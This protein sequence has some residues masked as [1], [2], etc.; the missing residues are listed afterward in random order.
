ME[1]ELSNNVLPK[2]VPYKKKPY[3]G[4]PRARPKKYLIDIAAIN[5]WGMYYNL[6][7]Q[8]NEAFTT[9]LYE[10]D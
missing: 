7:A 9:S 6:K 8:E 2:L 5:T 4:V 1:K 3:L 10:I